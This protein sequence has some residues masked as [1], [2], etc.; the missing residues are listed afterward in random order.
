MLAVNHISEVKHVDLHT[1]MR[2]S[3][4]KLIIKDIFLQSWAFLI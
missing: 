4:L 2:E 1:V 3:A